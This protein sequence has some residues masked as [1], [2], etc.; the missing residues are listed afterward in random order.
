VQKQVAVISQRERRHLEA[1]CRADFERPSRANTRSNWLLTQGCWIRKPVGSAFRMPSSTVRSTEVASSLFGR[2]SLINQRTLSSE[3]PRSSEQF[4]EVAVFEDVFELGGLGE[5]VRLDLKLERV[6]RCV[7][8]D[9]VARFEV[10]GPR[11]FTNS[12]D[13][14]AGEG[15]SF[16]SEP[17]NQ[18]AWDLCIPV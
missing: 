1:T 18:L 8:D 13:H 11:A 15:T 2:K 4:R 14:F 10:Q 16:A 17:G 6:F 12:K 9:R 5:G 3:I 7:L